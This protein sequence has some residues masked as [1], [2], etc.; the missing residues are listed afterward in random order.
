VEQLQAG[1]LRRLYTPRSLSVTVPPLLRTHPE[2]RERIRRLR[3]LAGGAD[4]G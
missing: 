3:A 2:T 1:L 4:A